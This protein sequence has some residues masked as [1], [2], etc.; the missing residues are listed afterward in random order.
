MASQPLRRTP[1]ER[2]LPDRANP[3]LERAI[4][5]RDARQAPEVDLWSLT[6]AERVAAFWDG[7]LTFRQCLEWSRHAQHEVPKAPDGEFLYIACRTPEWL[8]E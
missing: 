7:R 4:E 2:T 3:V 8:G 6:R 1:V 5:Q